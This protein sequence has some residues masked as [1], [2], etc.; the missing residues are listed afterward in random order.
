LLPE[1]KDNFNSSGENGSESLFAIQFFADSG[2]SFNGAGADTL[3]FPQGGP[4]GSCCGFYTP[5][6]D[7]ANAFK[8]DANGLPL[9]DTYNQS[10]IANDQG[11]ADA[12]P[13]TPEAGNLDPR[14]DF[15]I[16]RR[17]IDY[18]GWGVHP[19]QSWQRPSSSDIGG[20]YLPKKNVYQA[21]DDGLRGR[22]GWGEE[23]SGINWHAVRYAD[24]LLLAAEAAVETGALEKARG[25]VNQVRE[26]AMNMTWVKD[27]AGNN[28]ANYVIGLY[29]SAWTDAAVARK[30]VR[31]ERRLELGMEGHRLTDLRRYGN[32]AE[33]MAAY[34]ENES[35]TVTT[36][37]AKMNPYKS[38]Y[39]VFPIPQNAIDLS[40]GVL[41]QNPGY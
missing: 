24:V 21:G 13:F 34:V 23:R 33:V 26:R 10:D 14:I 25:Y 29:N 16:G 7:L 9:L 8:T 41:Q 20:P 37:K 39:E 3:N 11:L 1:L 2:Q 18:N 35:R 5:T 4:F 28:A 22:G 31:M 27:E 36:L 12:D 40:G 19:G 30:A 38:A 17:G 32:M 6:Q 15:T